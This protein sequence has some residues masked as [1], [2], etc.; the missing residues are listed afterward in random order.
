[1]RGVRN[2]TF[3]LSGLMMFAC[4]ILQHVR[5]GESARFRS[6]LTFPSPASLLLVSQGKWPSEERST[7]QSCASNSFRIP[8]T[9][10]CRAC[11]AVGVSCLDGVLQIDATSWLP[12]REWGNETIG[13][14]TQFYKCFNDECCV[15][16]G[17][18]A[19]IVACREEKGYYGPLCGACDRDN[20]RGH[21][22]F[23]RSGRGCFK[24]W[25]DTLVWLASMS[26]AIGLAAVVMYLVALHTFA[27]PQGEYSATVQKILLSHLQMLGVLGIFKAKGTAVFN[28]IVNRPAE[29]IGGSFTSLMPIKCALQ[30]QVYGPFLL[31]MALPAIVL[32]LAGVAMIP[33]IFWERR[34]RAKRAKESTPTPA[35]KGKF[36]LPRPLAPC[37]ILRRPMTLDDIKVWHA[38]TFNAQGRFAGVAVFAMFS[39]Y[40]TLVSSI[41][42][43]FNCTADVEGK[44]YLV[45]DLSVVC[46]EARHHAFTTLAVIGSVVYAIGIPLTIAYATALKTPI[47]CRRKVK[48]G[49]G[50]EGAAGGRSAEGM[51][52]TAPKCVCARRAREAYVRES[53][54]ALPGAAISRPPVR[55]PSSLLLSSR[56]CDQMRSRFAF[57][58]NGY[59]TTRSGVVVSWEAI[60]MLRKLTVTLA[61]SAVRDPYLQILSAQLILLVSVIATAYIQPYE[62]G[63]L[64][65]L[66]IAGL[67]A[68]ILTQV[69]SILYFYAESATYPFMEPNALEVSERSI[70][71]NAECTL[72]RL[73]LHRVGTQ[74]HRRLLS[75]SLSEPSIRPS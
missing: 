68:L 39:L 49:E 41:A 32:A 47:V 13:E 35:F 26:L 75:R 15:Q 54:S 37:R 24:C 73:T 19:L 50:E 9:A 56:A 59:S 65:L 34:I 8:N 53:V 46:Y 7:C 51:R 30:S 55:S 11:P 62:T 69:L 70:A 29:I 52:W 61:G 64:N 28:E 18:F 5:A 3:V 48:H 33:K 38:T 71:G 2:G 43:I 57:L 27:A 4:I 40:P 45:A 6:A 58:Y 21:G 44:R 12:H 63:W 10:T 23:T 67:F 25:P 16:P 42:S 60:V 17:P 72:R 20:A 22:R 31:N 36:N 66:D 74:L 14:M 1:M